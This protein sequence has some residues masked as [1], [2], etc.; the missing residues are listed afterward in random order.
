VNVGETDRKDYSITSIENDLLSYVEGRS[1][2]SKE[3]KP[4]KQIMELM[5]CCPYMDQLRRTSEKYRTVLL[6]L[7]TLVRYNELMKRILKHNTIA[8]GELELERYNQ[9]FKKNRNL[10]IDIKCLLGEKDENQKKIEKMKESINIFGVASGPTQRLSL[11][12]KT[13]ATKRE[14]VKFRDRLMQENDVLLLR[15]KR[16]LE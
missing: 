10:R 12:D 8:K 13:T 2:D 5:K 15:L 14:L 3:K 16:R 1:I 11:N 4:N 9:F 7:E 6:M